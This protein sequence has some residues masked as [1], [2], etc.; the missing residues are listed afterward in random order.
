VCPLAR[1]DRSLQGGVP[2]VIPRLTT[3][4]RIP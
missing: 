1:S 2:A 3:R 4:G